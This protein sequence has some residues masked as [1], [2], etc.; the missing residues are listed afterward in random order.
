VAVSPLARTRAQV[1]RVVAR[2]ME[3]DVSKVLEAQRAEVLREI[4]ANA[5]KLA[6][7]PDVDAIWDDQKWDRAMKRAVAGNATAAAETVAEQVQELFG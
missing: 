7:K 1:D 4:R 6:R 2:S 3:R 5:A